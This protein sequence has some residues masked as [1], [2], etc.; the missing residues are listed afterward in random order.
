MSSSLF[1]AINNLF[2]KLKTPQY[3]DT[4]EQIIKNI[5]RNAYN[6]NEIKNNQTPLMYAINKKVLP[7]FVID[8]I[9]TG[10]SN[11]E[12]VNSNGDTAFILLFKNL[13]P[14]SGVLNFQQSSAV[15][16][17]LMLIQTGK[18]NLAQQN[19]EGKRAYDYAVE[20]G[21]PQ[22][23]NTNKNVKLI[24]DALLSE[25]EIPPPP[26]TT[27]ENDSSAPEITPP[28]PPTPDTTETDTSPRSF[29]SSDRQCQSEG[30]EPT[31]INSVRN[32]RE[33]TRIFHPD[34]NRDCISEATEKM[35]KLNAMYQNFQNLNS[36]ARGGKNK[37]SIKL[38]RRTKHRKS[39]KSRKS[40][41]LRR[42]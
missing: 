26:G 21:L 1:I 22:L 27:P 39:R 28:I 10:K 33:Q 25:A 8:F 2:S 32:Y 16:A 37:K 30:K 9:K 24:M 6:I 12:Y 31:P 36:R 17:I 11:P 15:P 5:S 38:R 34:K 14:I 35:K 19:I 13:G 18:V 23:A 20:Y 40:K 42:R 41:T 7:D 4:E 3:Y 29:A